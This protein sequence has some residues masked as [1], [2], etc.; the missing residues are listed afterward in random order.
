MQYEFLK[1]QLYL[2]PDRAI[3]WENKQ[4]LLLADVHLGKAGHFRKAGIPIPTQVHYADLEV[5]TKLISQYQP[6]SL[7]ILGD[8]FHSH[9]NSDWRIFE[10]WLADYPVLEINLVKGNHD[11]IPEFFFSKNSINIYPNTWEILP[12]VFSHIPLIISDIKADYY[13]L[14]GHLHPAVVLH[15]KAKQSLRLPCFYFGE[16][17]GYLPAFGNFTGVSTLPIKGQDKVF[18]IT[19]DKVL[20]I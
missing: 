5:I 19:E 4:M 12:F 2:L 3:W 17:Q 16:K 1:Q 14:C 11:I 18:V 20:K 15:G 10:E 9:L 8:L 7:T 6:Q 13:N